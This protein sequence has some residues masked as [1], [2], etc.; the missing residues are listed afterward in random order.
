M[1]LHIKDKS[2]HNTTNHMTT[3]TLRL[4]LDKATYERVGLE[5]KPIQDL[6]RKHTK[7]RYGTLWHST[8]D[9]QISDL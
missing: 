8:K 2:K 1:S 3:G 7:A 6:G 9:V 4:E 5:G